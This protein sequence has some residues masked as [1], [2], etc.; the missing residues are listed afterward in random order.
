MRSILAILL[1][2]R[3]HMRLVVFFICLP[4]QIFSQDNHKIDSLLLFVQSCPEDSGKIV[5][6]NDLG[7]ELLAMGEVEQAREMILS[8]HQLSEKL[9]FRKGKADFIIIW[10]L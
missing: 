5:A 2:S 10:A 6:L 8:A 9:N 7:D 4:F 1:Q 3:P